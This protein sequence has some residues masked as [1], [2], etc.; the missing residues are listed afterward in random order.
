MAYADYRLCDVC[1]EKAFYGAT[2]NYENGTEGDYKPYRVVG[3]EQYKDLEL[4]A[5]YGT[6]L[7]YIGD[8]A[9]ICSDCS[10]KFKTQ[11]VPI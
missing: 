5:N 3:K 8:W 7:D 6:R 9:V 2:L 1:G 4:H 11:I 10:M